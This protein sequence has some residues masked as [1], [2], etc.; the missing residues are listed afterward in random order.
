MAASLQPYLPRLIRYWD[1]DAP[2]QLHRSIEGSMVFVDIS[3]F[4]SMSERLAR[5]GKVGAEEVTDVIGDTFGRLLPEAYAFGANLLKFGGDALLLLFTGDGHARR[6]CAA[7]LGMRRTLR[8]V[9]VFRTTA[10]QVSLRMTVGIHSGQFDF[11]LVGRSHR[12]LVVAGPAATRTVEMEVAAQA[13][14]ILV[15]WDTAAALSKPNRGRES[16]PGVLLKGDMPDVDRVDFLAATSPDVDLNVFIPTALRETLL[17]GEVDPGHRPVSVA[18]LH[19]AGFDQL[20]EEV[21]VQAAAL[22]L[23]ELFRDVQ[24]AADQRAVTFLG[25]DIAP[26]GGKIILA[27]GV[28]NTSGQDGEQMLLALRAIVDARPAIPIQIGVTWG[29]VFA[30]EIGPPY[31]RTYTVM[32]DVVNLAAR[33]MAR[34]QQGQILTT[35]QMLAGSRTMFGVTP[36]EPFYVKGKAKP[37]Q[38]YSVEK[39]EGS[40]ARIVEATLP[41]IGRDAELAAMLTAW[42]SASAGNGIAFQVVA[43]AGMGKTRLLD[44]FLSRAG[45]PS[46]FHAECR[47]YQSATP[48]F[49]FRSLL[50]IVFGL[51]GLDSEEAIDALG[52]LVAA[53]APELTPWLSLIGL[54]LDLHI[55]ESPEVAQ[56]EDQFR[57][58]RTVESVRQLMAAVVTEP[59]IFLIEDTHWMDE[60]SGNLLSALLD[61]LET[62]PWMICVSRRPGED[63]WS[64][65]DER[66]SLSITLAP[67]EQAQA[68]S[69]IVSA[70]EGSLMPQQIAVL[71]QRAEGN[72]LFLIELVHALKQGGSLEVLPQS[73]EGLIGARIDKLPSLDRNLLRRAAVLGAGFR[74]EHMGAVLHEHE[75][76]PSWKVQAMHR[77]SGFL[78]VD[79]SGWVQFRH[80]LIRDVAYGGLPYRVRQALHARI[81]DA[82]RAGESGPPDSQAELLSIHYFHAKRWLDAWVFSRIAGSDAKSLYANTEA[83]IF[84]ERALEA[85]RHLPEVANSERAEVHTTLGDVLELAGRFEESL[86]AYRRASRLVAGDR[87]SEGVLLLKR[88]RARMHAGAYR[89]AMSEATRG[90]KAVLASDD[91]LAAKT[92]ARLAALRALIRQ[93]Q[94]RAADAL[95]LSVSAV[96]EAKD[97][98]DDEALARAYL[99]MD[100]AYHFLGRPDQAVHLEL[101][102]DIYERLGDLDGAGNVMNNLGGF[103]YFD[104][105]WD[106]ALAWYLR[107]QDAYRRAGNEVSAAVAGGNIGEL[108]VSQGRLVEAEP[109]L[110]EAVRVLR[111][112]RALDDVLFAEIQLDRLKVEKGDTQ[113]A[114]M[115][116]EA[117][118]AEATTLGQSGYAF[119]AALHLSFAFLAEGRCDQAWT[120]LDDAE[121]VAGGVDPLYGPSVARARTMA[122]IKMGQLDAAQD[123]VLPGISAAQEQGLAYEEAMLRLLKVEIRR[124]T[125]LSPDP[126]DIE[127]AEA[128]LSKC[129]V[130][131]RAHP[132]QPVT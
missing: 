65:P 106:T 119:E 27:A 19:F 125:G 77:L 12:E 46:V 122:L 11:F 64:L 18:F 14:Q 123:Q 63:G 28:P 52:R 54:V 94:Q 80:A 48:Y 2:G 49:L 59:A 10:G 102:L 37:V 8:E 97:A 95:R 26:D 114:I 4:T 39:A 58:P 9:R 29:P 7:A 71:A 99:V 61:G 40:R 91:P 132:T 20:M 116:L 3:G 96:E 56:L 131:P 104:G 13:G 35:D 115:G 45:A 30:G 74:A 129:G 128:L 38:A 105:E 75:S 16:G 113:A 32:G 68:E 87:A 108:L 70:S 42:K 98:D 111:A 22:A 120:L 25:T 15:S 89:A 124:A 6:A 24:E 51:A 31:R 23:D 21:G 127:R 126:G 72:P 44:E 55:Q 103:A 84:F 100:W 36:L 62:W 81:G 130:R 112:A 41:L 73:V 79:T 50:P 90:S 53:E 17:A 82:I 88:A 1:Q 76:D 85:A 66:E 86:L 43:E 47:L 5:H 101:A 34:S 109:I 121:A 57:R 69:I 33:L 83:A 118:R 117:L 78:A 107:A 60:A 67:L 92:R 110:E 93:A